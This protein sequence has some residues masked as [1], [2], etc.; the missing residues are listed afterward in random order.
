[1]VVNDKSKCI[2][3]ELI[4]LFMLFYVLFAP[5]VL[6]CVLFVCKCVLYYCH[7]LSTQLQ[8]NISYRINPLDTELNPICHLL[9]LLGTHP[10]F[11]ISRIRVKITSSPSVTIQRF[12][13][14]CIYYITLN[15]VFMSQKYSY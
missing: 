3:A 6:F 11:H 1:M 5:T 13:S 9:A 8:L 15:S 10:I 4:L 12:P 14:I 7:R 2:A